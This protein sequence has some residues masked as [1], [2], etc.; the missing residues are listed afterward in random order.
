MSNEPA[1][2]SNAINVDTANLRKLA[3]D[4]L[5]PLSIISMGLEILGHVR[6]DDEQFER[7]LKMMS[8]EGVN[9]LKRAIDEIARQTLTD[10]DLPAQSD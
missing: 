9:P 5:T 1:Q 8:S 3:H 6:N 10:P 7:M 4:L 2:S